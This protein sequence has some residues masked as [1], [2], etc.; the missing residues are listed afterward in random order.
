MLGSFV[1]LS[2]FFCVGVVLGVVLVACDIL[3]GTDVTGRMV[4][5][6]GNEPSWP[7]PC[8]EESPGSI[9]QIAR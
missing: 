5:K 2:S 1:S 8:S 3:R 7:R 9:G 6:Q 4:A